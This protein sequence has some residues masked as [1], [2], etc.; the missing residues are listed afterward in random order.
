M[1]AYQINGLYEVATEIGNEAHN[2]D[3]GLSTETADHDIVEVIVDIANGEPHKLGIE[4][5][6]LTEQQREAV[7]AKFLTAAA[8]TAPPCAAVDPQQ[9]EQHGCCYR[10]GHSSEF[11]HRFVPTDDHWSIKDNQGD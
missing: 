4:L 11:P 7:V 1:L 3:G 2:P 8:D 10:Q 9:R 6:S 5:D